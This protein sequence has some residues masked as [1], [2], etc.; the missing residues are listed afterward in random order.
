VAFLPIANEQC[1][2]RVK[3]TANSPWRDLPGTYT[4]SE[5]WKMRMERL[6]VAA[7]LSDEAPPKKVTSDD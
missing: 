5:M 4:T 1:H 3:D 7:I 6:F 2:W